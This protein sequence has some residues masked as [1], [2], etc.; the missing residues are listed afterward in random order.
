MTVP[1][2][3]FSLEA[4]AGKIDTRADCTADKVEKMTFKGVPSFVALDQ[5]VV[6]VPEIGNVKVD[7]AYG[8]MWYAVVDADALGLQLVPKNGKA[9]CRYGEMIKIAC[10]EQWPVTHPENKHQG[11]EI[12]VFRSKTCENSRA[13]WKNAV[14]MSNGALDWNDQSTW[15][16][17]LDRSPCGTGT[18]AVMAVLHARGQL[19]LNQEFIHES[20]LG[21]LFT[22][23]L[24]A[25]AKVGKFPAVVP[26]IS[27]QAWITAHSNLVVHPTD[28]FPQ[29]YTV[30]DIWA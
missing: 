25:T 10:R 2:T 11:C 24:I 23:K 8:G 6:Q 3:L 28:P 19:S 20:I 18:C 21:S 13:H 1:Q 22:G 26:E 27:G 5:V 7:V 16:G 9:V 30:S 4:P 14:V 17:M 15:T 12:L 29:G